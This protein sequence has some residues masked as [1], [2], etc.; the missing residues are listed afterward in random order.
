MVLDRIS[1][2]S[3]PSN[4]IFLRTGGLIGRRV[5]T[6]ISGG[7]S[8]GRTGVAGDSG[9][10]E[11]RTVT[12]QLSYAIARCCATVVNYNRYDYEI[13]GVRDVPAGLPP[14]M[15]RDSVNVGFSLNLPLYDSQRRTPRPRRGL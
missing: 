11:N 15:K 1:R 6:T 9:R 13:V 4:T 14:S 10:Y 7:Y 2:E 5:Q 3:F 12:A 8:S